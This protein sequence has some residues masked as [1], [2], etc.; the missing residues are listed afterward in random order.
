M[1]AMRFCVLASGSKGNAT[2]VE[3]GGVRLLIDAGLACRTLEGRLR[4]VG[5]D[6]AGLDAVLVTHEHIDHVAGLDRF[7]RKHGVAVYANEGTAAVIERQCRLAGRE[8]PEFAIFESRV[9]F[10]LGG[11][12]V[13]PVRVSH[14]TAEPVAYTL[15][16]GA[17]RLGYF[18]DL[19]FVSDEVRLAM[20]GCAAMVL[21]SNHDV[22]MLH[23]SGRPFALVARI[24]GDSG[25]L[26]NEQAC[27]AMEAVCPDCLRALV[28][29]HLS[30]DCND[31]AVARNLMARALRK[32][33][34]DAVTLAVA[35]QETALPFIEL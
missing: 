12:T 19:G 27:A 6:P 30:Q 10:A 34:R 8:A 14:D 33:G 22:G 9:P 20:A 21:E 11:V 15:D 26:S 5:A 25:H 4:E 7:A 35:R 29:A 17:A 3:A 1:G 13:T 18:T 23:A 24:Q 28:L 31:A 2:Y 32:L 16:D